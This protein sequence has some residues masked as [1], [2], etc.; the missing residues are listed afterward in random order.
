M[1]VREILQANVTEIAG[2]GGGVVMNG[3]V[4]P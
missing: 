4:F 2:K 3:K 1:K